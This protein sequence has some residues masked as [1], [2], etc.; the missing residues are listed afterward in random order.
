[1]VL[2]YAAAFVLVVIAAWRLAP[3]QAAATAPA[4]G[5]PEVGLAH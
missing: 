1:M 4:D 5:R 3:A 2:V